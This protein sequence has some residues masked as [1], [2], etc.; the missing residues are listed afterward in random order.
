MR[1]ARRR[2][3]ARGRGADHLA[4]RGHRVQGDLAEEREVGFGEEWLGV[5]NGL[6]RLDPALGRLVRKADDPPRDRP[7]TERHQDAPAAAKRAAGLGR[8]AIGVGLAD[9]QGD[10][11]LGQGRPVATGR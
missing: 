6:D 8:D 2:H 4:Q 1:P 7:R 10:G 5:G 3:A 11:Y 9:R